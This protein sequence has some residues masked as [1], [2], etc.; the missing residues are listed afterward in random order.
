[1]HQSTDAGNIFV[2]FALF[3]YRMNGFYEKFIIKNDIYN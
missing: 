2:C 1:M 3:F